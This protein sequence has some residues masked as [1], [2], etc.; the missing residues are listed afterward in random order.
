MRMYDLIKKKKQGGELSKDEIEIMIKGYVKGDIPDYQMSA[1]LMAI[2]FQGMTERETADLTIA[3]AKSGDM[4]DLTPIE[5]IKVDKHSTG[6]VGDKTTLVIAPIVA[7]CGVKVAKMSGRGLGHTGG[8]IDKL[9]AIPGMETAIDK[10]RFFHIVNKVGVSVVGQT[11]NLAPADKKLYALRD[12]TATVDSIPLIAASIMSKK[13]A[14]GSDCIVLDVKTGSGAFMNSLDDSIELARRMVSI[15]EHAGKDTVAIITDM[16]IPL[17]YNIGNSLEVIE[18]IETLQG[19]GPQD[20]TEVSL[21]LASNMLYLAK[22][23]TIEEC[24]TMAKEAISSGKALKKLIEM[25]EIQGGDSR[26]IM[27]TSQFASAPYQYEVKAKTEG[28]ISL[29]NTEQCGIAS[30]TLGAGRETRDSSI[31]YTAGIK[32]IK[33]TGDYVTEGEVIAILYASNDR[34]FEKAE[35]ILSKAYSFSEDPVKTRPLLLA[36][37][38]A[39]KVEKF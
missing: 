30:M 31:D 13:L 16:D 38:T 2:C 28:Y 24:E 12:V 25:V 17:G 5:G 33:K 32:L 34:L 6:G 29:M 23:G 15:G 7:A 18:A 14:A 22:K 4:V 11:G 21:V 1:L 26:V 19:N 39:N 8:T 9:E 27:D 3:M 10:A 20:L 36:K 35:Q 37:V